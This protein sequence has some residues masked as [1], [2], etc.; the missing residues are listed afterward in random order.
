MPLPTMTSFVTP[1]GLPSLFP[2]LDPTPQVDVSPVCSIQYTADFVVAYDYLRSVLRTDER[3]D[4]TLKLTGLCLKL[5]PANYTVWHFRRRILGA[6]KR[7][8]E[9]GDAKGCGDDDGDEKLPPLDVA[10]LKSE[11]GLASTLGGANP[12]NYQIWYHRRAL[13]EP[14][15]AAAAASSSADGTGYS[16]DAVLDVAKGEL[17]YVSTVLAHDAK[18]YHAWSHRQYVLRSSCD[19]SA[20]STNL[21]QSDL[22]YT[23]T[24]ISTDMRNNSAWNHRWFVTHR[25][26]HVPLSPDDALLECKYALSKAELDPHNESPWIY[27]VG[28][29]KEQVRSKTDNDVDAAK[30]KKELVV[31][32]LAEAERIR[33]DIIVPDV[34][35][36]NADSARI[37]LL[38]VL[39]SL[40][41]DAEDGRDGV[42]EE[43]EARAK[44]AALAHKLGTLD[45]TIRRKYWARREV[46]LASKKTEAV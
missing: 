38:D 18:N 21:W 2:D 32:M 14:I 19:T 29:V 11:Q 17:S 35:C 45:D 22:S 26:L 1:P 13:L 7:G 23:D 44:A 39:S 42:K 9:T 25:G 40:I 8:G 46:Q 34:A 24:L 6:L 43:E 27:L 10:T 33:K 4:R 30:K 41:G 3:S 31:S 15:F 37:E 12:K 5:N 28:L 36:P 20:T 16:P